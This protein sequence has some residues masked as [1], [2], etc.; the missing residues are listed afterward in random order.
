MPHWNTDVIRHLDIRRA[1]PEQRCEVEYQ[2]HRGSGH[3]DYV[4]AELTA[5]R[6]EDVHL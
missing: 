3:A 1:V 2:H 5:V 4:R 6:Q